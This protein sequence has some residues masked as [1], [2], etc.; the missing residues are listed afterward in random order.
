[1]TGATR[2]CS[3][4]G[5]KTAGICRTGKRATAGLQVGQ[6][7]S[8]LPQEL[9]DQVMVCVNAS[10]PPMGRRDPYTDHWIGAAVTALLAARSPPMAAVLRVSRRPGS[11]A[12]CGSVMGPGAARSPW[13]QGWWASVV[14]QYP[15]ERAGQRLALTR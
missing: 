2:R 1:M 4:T 7:M 3:P 8:L 5:S 9:G 10:R 15:G 13:V 6:T 11:V 14:V 12:E